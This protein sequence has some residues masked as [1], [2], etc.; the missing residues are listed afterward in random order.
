MQTQRGRVAIFAAAFLIA[1]VAISVGAF[2]LLSHK[3]TVEVLGS[4]SSTLLESS[5]LPTALTA[6]GP[7]VSQ[8]TGLPCSN[9]KNGI[10][11]RPLGVMFAGDTVARPLS[12]IADADV[13]IEM[14]VITDSINRM[15][16]IFQCNAVSEIGSVRSAR[17]DFI[18]LAAG[19]DAIYGHWGGS[20]FALD[21]L[22]FGIINNI[23]AL[24]NPYGAYF[25]KKGIS[26]PHNGFTSWDRLY[27]AAQKLG[28]RLT[29]EFSGYPHLQESGADSPSF[30]EASAGGQEPKVMKIG[31]PGQ[32]RVEWRYDATAK[33]FLRFRGGTPE[34]DRNTKK[35]VRA[36]T[37]A[38]MRTTSRQIE[39]QYNTVK[40]IGEG[41]ASIFRF[42]QEV[43]GKWQKAESPQSSPLRFIGENGVDIEFAPGVVWI[44]IVQTNT[45]VEF[46]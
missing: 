6:T 14:P 27:G 2:Y 25:R 39:G 41:P 34:L 44:E 3:R 9:A 40:V 19:F 26:S 7:V 17:D 38:V 16:A 28:Y 18:P 36:G 8:I 23:D 22:N 43:Q 1:I 31:Y 10:L 30:A 12:G 21:K 45:K 46:R 37:V 42:G 24:R 33:T 15:L 35:Q 5:S 11:P 32:F 20:H 13:V 29:T 4:I